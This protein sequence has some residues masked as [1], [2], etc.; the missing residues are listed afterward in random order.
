[1]IL[2]KKPPPLAA[3][4]R[5]PSP[6]QWPP[7]SA[8]SGQDNDSSKNAN[9]LPDEFHL[10]PELDAARV[11]PVADVAIDEEDGEGQQHRQHLRRRPHV[12]TGEEGKGQEAIEDEEELK[13]QFP[14]KEVVQVSQAVL[15]AVLQG[16]G[17]GGDDREGAGVR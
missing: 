17:L 7:R 3:V 4:P 5:P 1:M 6:G 12:V 2:L 10:I 16:V 11:V 9:V 8:V 15:L 14:P 13:G